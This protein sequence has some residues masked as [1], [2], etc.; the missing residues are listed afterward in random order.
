MIIVTHEMGFAKNVSDKVVFM[1]DGVI[2]EFGTPKQIF[3]A[4]KSEKLQAF[5]SNLDQKE[6]I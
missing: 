2:E 3:E 6:N 5:L 1:A 4:P